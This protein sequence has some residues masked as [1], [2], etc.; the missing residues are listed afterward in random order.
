VRRES[1]IFGTVME[2]LIMASLSQVIDDY[3][4]MAFLSEE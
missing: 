3:L 1:R 2:I 4:E